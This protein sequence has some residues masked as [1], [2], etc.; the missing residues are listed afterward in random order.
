MNERVLCV[1]DE[2]CVLDG[3]RRVL[4]RDFDVQTANSGDE[5]L[6]ILASS[7][8]FAVIV[9]DMRMPGM[10]GAEFL[11]HAR[12]LAPD[13]TRMLL[14]GQA[15]VDVAMEAIN[16]GGIFRF[17]RKPCP[18]PQ[19]LGALTDCVTQYRL[20]TDQRVLLEQTLH[21]SIDALTQVL[22]LAN[23]VAF[24]MAGRIRRRAG[25]FGRHLDVDDVWQL[26]I[27]AMLSQIGYATLPPEIV[28]KIFTA[29]RLS[30]SEQ[31]MVDRIPAT[32]ER[33]LKSIPRLEGVREILRATW[34]KPGPTVPLPASLLRI[35]LDYEAILGTDDSGLAID[36]LSGRRIYDD[37]LLASFR[38]FVG[39][40]EHKRRIREV[41]IRA[42]TTNMVLA[43]AIHSNAGVLLVPEGS[44]VT[45]SLQM[46]IDNMARRGSLQVGHVRVWVRAA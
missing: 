13:S 45:E 23:P 27:A 22:A 4:R 6:R 35:V 41:D 36:T 16:T 15:D 7:D 14:T 9:S 1:D 17:L 5:A 2:V 39:A 42:L 10:N 24:G 37:G 19:L 30:A 32:T 28:D 25:A 29:V 18:K 3:I 12:R 44:E 11:G 21:G 38:E 33:I 46:R 20:V 31:K 34:E 40:P 43:E 26:E 8:P